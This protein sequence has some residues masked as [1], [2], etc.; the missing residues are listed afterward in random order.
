MIFYLSGDQIVSDV[1]YKGWDVLSDVKFFIM[2]YKLVHN[3]HST[4]SH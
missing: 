2:H 3:L 4:L 1:I